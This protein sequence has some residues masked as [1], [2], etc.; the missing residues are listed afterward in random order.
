MKPPSTPPRSWRL[1]RGLI[2]A[3]LI[4]LGLLL[5]ADRIYEATV[6]QARYIEADHRD[7]VHEFAFNLARVVGRELRRGDLEAVQ[8]ELKSRA[9][10]RHLN[11]ILLTD[12]DGRIL[13]ATESRLIGLE[14]ARLTPELERPPRA[15]SVQLSQD[16]SRVLAHVEVE[17]PPA[18]DA[19]R[20]LE[21]GWL[22]IDYDLTWIKAENLHHALAPA[23][24]LRWAAGFVLLAGLLY[25]LLSHMVLKPLLYLRNVA[26]RFGN[27][28]WSA[29]ARLPGWG[30]L[31]DLARAFDS[32]ADEISEDRR[33]LKRSELY[34]KLL[35]ESQRTALLVI[36]GDSGRILDGN[37]AAVALFGYRE[38]DALIGKRLSDLS[39]ATQYAAEPSPACAQAHIARTLEQGETEFEWRCLRPNGEIWDAAAH[40]IRFDMDG[41]PLLLLSLRDITAAKR[42]AAALARSEA[43]WTQT[44]D[45]LKDVV[46]VLDSGRRL[47]RAN[48]AFYRLMGVTPEQAIGQHIV[49]IL[50]PNGETLPCPVCQAQE[51]R[52]EAIFTLEADHP[53]N[54][55]GRP[56]EVAVN[57]MHD[58]Q[59]AFCGFLVAIHDLSHA[60]AMQRALAE[61]ESRFRS[62]VE[63]LPGAAYRCRLDEN[64][65]VE[66]ISAGIQTL[67]GY[68]A[69]ALIGNRDL[70]FAS[71]IHPED[72]V[73]VAELIHAC[74]RAGQPYVL[75]YRIRC[76]DGQIRWLWERGGAIPDAPSALPHLQGVLFD[77]T[78]RKR[79]EEELERHRAHLE[80]LVRERTADLERARDAAEAANRAKSAFLAN[81]SHE[82]RTPLNAILGFAQLMANAPNLDAEQ[83]KNLLTINQSGQHLL[84]LINDVLEISRIEAGRLSLAPQPFDLHEMLTAL[85]EVLALRARDKGL[86]LQ[87]EKTPDLPRYLIA[88]YGKLRQILLNLLSNAVKYTRQGEVVLSAR[89]LG[90]ENGHAHLEFAVRDTGIGISAE[91]MAR[92]FQPFYQTEAGATQGEG[93]GLGLAIC[94]E[95]ARL[96]RAELT[97][98]STPGAGSVF[99]LRVTLPLAESAGPTHALPQAIHLAPGQPHYRVLVAEDQPDNQRLIEQWLTRAGFSVRCAANGEAAVAAFREWKP[100]FVWMDMRMPV[101]DGYA[102]TRAIRALPGGRDV[103]IVAL[104]ASAF[105][106]DRAAILEAGCD[107]VLIKPVEPG[108][109]FACMRRLLP[110]EFEFEALAPTPTPCAA[111]VNLS[112][113]PPA[114]RQRLAQAALILDAET[115][116]AVARECEAEYPEIAAFLR[117]EVEQYRFDALLD[118]GVK[119]ASS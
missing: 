29:R 101:M 53:H 12:A 49:D 11:Y 52:R 89:L 55:A 58:S 3:L 28:D 41:M 90:C 7:R 26:L 93:T 45:S 79:A 36:D 107:D 113:L 17:L 42:T 22:I 25:L 83:R 43:A 68:P 8:R 4:G 70:S 69:E 31:A 97:A 54:P 34:N 32:M 119:T 76:A 2:G 81:M 35:F 102:A 99:R 62:L 80:Q 20:A 37:P 118:T 85:S 106:E 48:R 71:L 77:I 108:Q 63:N 39:P 33:R 65:T 86:T 66:Y 59:G 104:T 73:R 67:T 96:M 44:M 91:D 114:M 60:R 21:P 16:R 9:D 88:D 115:V 19:L 95:Y 24:L 103:P 47:V 38:R 74:V 84:A 78:D 100:A 94:R 112:R 14:L 61:S 56:I 111:P 18:S 15:E 51:E 13:A 117:A 105:A 82:L 64:W 116:R 109:L 23:T 50:H 87:L 72:R 6:V 92:I 10:M 46:Y 98:E 30:E 57:P 1:Q 27:G 5:F 75:E 40:L 110:I